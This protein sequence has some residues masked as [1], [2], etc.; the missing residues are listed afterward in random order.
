MKF[1]KFRV[2][3]VLTCLIIAILPTSGSAVGMWDVFEDP[4]SRGA[5]TGNA[6]NQITDPISTEEFDSKIAK[7]IDYFNR[8]QYKEAKDEFTWFYEYNSSR[9]NAGQKQYINEYLQSAQ[10]KA[11][12][13]QS[14][15]YIEQNI[16]KKPHTPNVYKF[17]VVSSYKNKLYCSYDPAILGFINNDICNDL[18]YGLHNLGT[19]YSFTCYN[20]Y[21]YYLTGPVGTD[22]SPCSIYRC[23]MDGKNNIYIASNAYSDSTCYIVNDFLFYTTAEFNGEVLK[24]Q[25]VAKINLQTGEYNQIYQ[26]DGLIY[27]KYC[28]GNDLYIKYNYPDKQSFCIDNNGNLQYSVS[29]DEIEI[30][31]D[32]LIN[33]QA[34]K[35]YD[36]A[37][38][39]Y[40]REKNSKWLFNIPRVIGEY[41]VN[42]D[43]GCVENVLNNKI[44]YR[45]SLK[46][47]PRVHSIINTLLLR[48]DKNGQNTEL[49]GVCFIP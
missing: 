8:G 2:Y 38:Y 11:A 48:C 9:M 49:V 47:P 29:D 17:S 40:D 34:Y 19:I 13:D 3:I 20:G 7:G 16:N 21:I 5:Q 39:Q 1:K 10:Y 22:D 46:I 4:I 41:T 44:Y 26:A 6:N 18:P 32:C 23:N 24:K 12:L 27:I 42:Q 36:G 43:F 31:N 45:I 35:F 15:A 33:G 37:I 30:I 14:R 25:G 28:N